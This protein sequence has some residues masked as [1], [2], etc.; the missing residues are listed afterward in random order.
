MVGRSIPLAS[1]EVEIGK[2]QFPIFFEKATESLTCLPTTVTPLI[3]VFM[4][5]V[6]IPM[7]SIELSGVIM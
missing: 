7:R 5:I 4:L 6:P 3:L 1:F 2:S